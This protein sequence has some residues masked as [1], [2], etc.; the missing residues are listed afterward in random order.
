MY[1][2]VVGF[3]G[4][5]GRKMGHLS[6]IWYTLIHKSRL[7]N[8]PIHSVIPPSISVP[9][10][11]LLLKERIIIKIIKCEKMRMHPPRLA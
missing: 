2:D 4:G 7:K 6:S 11:H 10:E 9:S 8:K 1:S 5:G 3:W